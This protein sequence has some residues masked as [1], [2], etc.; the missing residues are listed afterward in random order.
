VLIE[1]QGLTPNTD[2]ET[3]Y[4]VVLKQAEATVLETTIYCF[5]SSFLRARGGDQVATS[6]LCQLL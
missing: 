3:K 2:S 1:L 5:A 4:G 6:R